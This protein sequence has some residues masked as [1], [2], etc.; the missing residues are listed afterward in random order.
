M[1]FKLSDVHR[2]TNGLTPRPEYQALLLLSTD[3]VY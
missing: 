3:E 1:P 2:A